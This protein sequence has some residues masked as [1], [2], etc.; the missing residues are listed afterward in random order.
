M[1]GSSLPPVICMRSP[2][3]F[4]LFRQA[5]QKHNTICIEHHY[6]QTKTNN[7]NK[8]G[9]LIQMTGGK[10]EPNIVFIRKSSS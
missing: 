8:T 3:L 6:T 7:V 10:D 1:F 2:V 9:D 5:K 4:T